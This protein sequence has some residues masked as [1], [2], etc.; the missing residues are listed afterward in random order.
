MARIVDTAQGYRLELVD[1]FDESA[2]RDLDQHLE[3]INY[4]RVFEACAQI[5][6]VADARR[7][8]AHQPQPTT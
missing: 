2:A 5:N 7:E 8:K 6:R 1:Q 3:F 4:V